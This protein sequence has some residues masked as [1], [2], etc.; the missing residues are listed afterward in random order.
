MSNPTDRW[1][2][3]FVDDGEVQTAH[4]HVAR[5]LRTSDQASELEPD[6]AA[7]A[8]KREAIAQVVEGDHGVLAAVATLGEVGLRGDDQ[9]QHSPD[10]DRENACLILPGFVIIGPV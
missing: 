10:K 6:R 5:R 4:D 7:V 2:D 8:C 9:T 3:E 1:E